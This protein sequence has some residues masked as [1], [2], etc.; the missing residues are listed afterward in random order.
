MSHSSA[1]R[2]A[3]ANAHT[4]GSHS[5]VSGAP[6]RG[7][8]YVRSAGG[9]W[10]PKTLGAAG[11]MLRSDGADPQWSADGSALTSL[12]ASNV[13]SGTLADARLSA[14]VPLKDAAAT[15][16]GTW[17]FT[18]GVTERGRAAKIGEWTDVAYNA[19]N[20][21]ASGTMTWTVVAGNH[22]AYAYSLVGKTLTVIFNFQ[23]TNVGGAADISLIIPIPGGLVSEL[24]VL[25]SIRIRNAA[26]YLT[27]YAV[28]VAG[29]TQILFRRIDNTTWTLTAGGDTDVTGQITFEVQ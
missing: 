27:G 10:V 23:N 25:N 5:D 11:T 6:S 3:I 2:A 20:F 7:D 18:P 19:A 8:I 14:N 13:S 12:N 26:T 28:V 24:Q 22:V 4:L 21:T 29:G 17:D 16:G 15:I 9:L 1:T